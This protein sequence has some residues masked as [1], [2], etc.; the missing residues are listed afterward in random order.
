MARVFTITAGLENMGAMKTGG[1]GSVYKGKRMGEIFTAIKILPTPIYSES[2]DDKNFLAFQNE[3]HKLQKV[4]EKT[5]PNVVRIVSSGITD[6]GNLPYI[7]MEFIEGPDLEE[8]I[9]A[10]HD[11]IFTLKEVIKVAEQLSHALA[12]CHRFDV[13]H[14]DIK[15]NNVKFNSNTGNYVLLDF[16]LAIMSDEQRRSSL[17]HAGA[18]EFMA[19]EQNEGQMLFETDVYSFGVVLFELLAGQVP[20]P[21]GEKGETA[22][23]LVMVAHMEQSPPDL[24]S[25]RQS[26][27]P[28]TW[29]EQKR[30]NEMQVPHWLVQLV[31]KCL[32]KNPA[33]RFASGLELHNFIVTHSVQSYHHDLLPSNTGLLQ[34][35]LNTLKKENERLRNELIQLRRQAPTPAFKNQPPPLPADVIATPLPPAKKDSNFGGILLAFLLTVVVIAGVYYFIKK[36]DRQQKLPEPVSKTDSLGRNRVVGEYIVTADRAYFYNEPSED[37]RRNAYAIASSEIIK[38]MDEKNGYIYSEITNDRGITSKGWLRKQDMVTLSAWLASNRNQAPPG[39]VM[40]EEEI[41]LKL[42]EARVMLASKRTQ[43]AVLIYKELS[44]KGVPEAT[45]QYANMALQN[46]HNQLSCNDAFNMLR[47]L[48]DNGY[49]PAKRT[50]GFLYAFA[51]DDPVLLQNNYDRCNFIKDV[52]KGSKLLMEVMVIGDTTARRLLDDLNAK[53]QLEKQAASTNNQQ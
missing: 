2:E 53:A 40:S 50:V 46:Q 24:L 12:H 28:H 29:D 39:D 10:P 37:S 22:R 32:Q 33:D 42:N 41:S 11:P 52:N 4:N 47:K 48:S 19:P 18:I 16:G 8:L 25:L 35:E 14:G 5:N 36:D 27:L 20:F 43:A 23:N 9:K 6:S 30:T 31:Y 1:Q 13:K 15:S 17:R 51:D 49:V 26:S 45:Y 3:V 21:L 34:Q 44:D 7:E 38:A